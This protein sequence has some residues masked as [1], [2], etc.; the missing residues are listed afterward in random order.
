M[1][2]IELTAQDMQVIMMALYSTEEMS[3]QAAEL[4]DK[5]AGGFDRFNAEH[6]AK[7]TFKSR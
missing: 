2:T 5:L 4:H 7:L 6:P 3:D 1:E